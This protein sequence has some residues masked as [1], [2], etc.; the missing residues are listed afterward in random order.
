M[1]DSIIQGRA[2]ENTSLS[3][4]VSTPNRPAVVKESGKLFQMSRMDPLVTSLIQLL[5]IA[6]GD[7]PFRLDD[8]K[9][10]FIIQHLAVKS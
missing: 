8:D 9:M 2:S 5:A 10:S 3:S 6:E 7:G 1:V 4:V